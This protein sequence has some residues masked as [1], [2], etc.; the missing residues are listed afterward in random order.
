MNPLSYVV[1]TDWVIDHLNEKRLV[2]DRLEQARLKGLAMSVVSLAELWEGVHYSRDFNK[3]QQQLEEFLQG[4]SLLTIT[5]ETCMIF[6]KLRG[7]LRSK[8]RSIPDFDLMIA[9]TALEH[10]LTLLSNNR[11]HFENIPGLRLES[12]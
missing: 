10:G 11:R 2:R 1:D 7:D 3:S 9:S 6:G 8:G 12:V 5:A 4:T